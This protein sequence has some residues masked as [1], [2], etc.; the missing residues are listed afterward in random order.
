MIAPTACGVKRASLLDALHGAP[1]RFQDLQL[2]EFRQ[3]FPEL[4]AMVVPHLL[5][6]LLELLGD[7]EAILL[8]HHGFPRSNSATRF[9]AN[10]SHS[11]SWMSGAMWLYS[12]ASITMTWQCSCA[13]VFHRWIGSVI[14]FRR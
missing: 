13:S 9:D 10:A 4:G 1:H 14:S 7:P 8:L 3:D 6:E 12:P 11:N 2:R 5:P